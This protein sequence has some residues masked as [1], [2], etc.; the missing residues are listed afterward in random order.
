MSRRYE[1]SVT[2]KQ[3]NP[4]KYIDIRCALDDFCGFDD[5]R[6][7]KCRTEA[8]STVETELG[9]G[10]WEEVFAKELAQE[11][12]KANGGHCKVE[13]VLTCLSAAPSELYTFTGKDYTPPP[14]ENEDE[15]Y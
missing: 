2:I 4:N 13:I 7:T 6:E 12:F 11:V 10:K 3:M 5:W 8:W 14:C 9:G 1:A 15:N